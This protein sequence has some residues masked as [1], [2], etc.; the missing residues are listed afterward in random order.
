MSLDTLMRPKRKSAPPP[1]ERVI[2]IALKDTPAYRAWFDMLSERTLI[3]AANVVR[4]ALAKWAADR[5]LPPPPPS[6]GRRRRRLE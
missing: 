6:V 5:G 3:P 4:D 2:V 1:D